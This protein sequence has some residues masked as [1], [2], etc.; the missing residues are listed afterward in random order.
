M[1]R[2]EETAVI[3]RRA[4]AFA[5]FAHG[6]IGQA[7]D[8]HGRRLIDFIARGCEIDLDIDKIGIDAIDG[9][10]QGAEKHGSQFTLRRNR[11]TSK[12]VSY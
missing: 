3:D 12:R 1:K 6:Q 4:N 11:T 2:K 8:D 7:N 5:R 9:G 10:G